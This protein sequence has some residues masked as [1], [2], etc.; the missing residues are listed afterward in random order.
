MTNLFALFKQDYIQLLQRY[1]AEPSELLRQ[2]AYELSRQAIECK[3]NILDIMQ[4]HHEQIAMILPS[5]PDN[6]GHYDTANEF[7]REVLVPFEI[8][9]RSYRD[10]NIKLIDLN[11]DLIK[12][13]DELTT[14]N[15]ELAAFSYSVSHDLRAPLRAIMGFSQILVSDYADT[16]NNTAKD[17]IYRIHHSGNK[18]EQLIDGMLMLSRLSQQSMAIEDV[19]LAKITKSILDDLQKLEPERQVTFS[20]PESVIAKGDA[21]LLYVVLQ[22]L[23]NNAWKFTRKKPTTSIEL[24]VTEENN[25]PVYFIRDNGAGFDMDY[26]DKLFSL[27]NRL[28]AENEFEGYGIGLATVQRIIHRHGGRIWA[29]GKVDE[30]ATFYFVL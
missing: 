15:K 2:K 12:K 6:N 29:E 4:V 30:G 22:N 16:L 7:L 10:A 19:D 20:S 26:A 13:S 17:L 23:L 24:G 3:I 14:L 27:F 1:L 28:H 5:L 21:K 18:M 25:K 8:I 11:Q 9:Y